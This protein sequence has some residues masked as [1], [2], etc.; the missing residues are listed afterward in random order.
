MTP[1]AWRGVTGALL[2][3]NGWFLQVLEGAP[4]PVAD[5]YASIQRDRR[6]HM[7][8]LVDVRPTA[9]RWFPRW[10]MCAAQLGPDDKSLISI[11]GRQSA[12]SPPALTFDLALTE[13][14]VARNL[15]I[16]VE[17][18]QAAGRGRRGLAS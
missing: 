8:A 11:L 1:L 4:D 5:I 15:V 14:G 12:F 17:D 2:C 18:F 13:A 7:E 16:R 10:A 3:C 6:H 9:E